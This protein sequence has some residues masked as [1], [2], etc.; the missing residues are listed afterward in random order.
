MRP[1]TAVVDCPLHRTVYE[2]LYRHVQGH[3]LANF[4]DADILPVRTVNLDHGLQLI[5]AR[6]HEIQTPRDRR[7]PPV[8]DTVFVLRHRTGRTY[9]VNSEHRASV[10]PT[11]TVARHPGC[12]FCRFVVPC[13]LVVTT[14]PHDAPPSSPWGRLW[15]WWCRRRAWSSITPPPTELLPWMDDDEESKKTPQNEHGHGAGP[16]QVMAS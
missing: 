3:N 11:P 12:D 16:H 9:L 14:P 1:S 2:A 15:A 7:L 5:D 8:H 4:R 6:T 13:V 10:E